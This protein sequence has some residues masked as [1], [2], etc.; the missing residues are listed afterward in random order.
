MFVLSLNFKTADVLLR[1]KFAFDNKKAL[2]LLNILKL[3]NIAE[4]VYLSTCNRCE[5]YG[6]GDVYFAI[7]VFSD[8]AEIS[9]ETVKKHILIFD[10]DGAVRHLFRV[11]SGIESMVFGEDEILGQI[12]KAFAFSQN[13]NATGYELNTIFKGAITSAKRIKT[14]T[15]ISKSSVSVATLAAS[16][17]HNFNGKS[18]KVLMIGGSGEIGS[19]VLK[20]LISYGEFDIYAT[21]RENHISNNN[22]TIIS[23]ADRY[24]YVNDADIIISAT[25]SPHFTI[26]ADRLQ[27]SIETAKERLFIDLAVPRDIDEDIKSIPDVS[28][29][30]IDDFKDIAK[31]NSEIKK[32]EL[33]TAEDMMC[34]DIDS[35]L[36]ELDFHSIVSQIQNINDEVRHFIYDFR[37]TANADEFESFINVFSKMEG[38]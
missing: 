6:V 5:I 22:L 35:L 30:Q 14:Q 32:D 34:E 13:N 12:K 16:K 8:F 24:K 36:K 9:E 27:K 11:C 20:D 19:K 4:C 18:K 33:K 21:A 31:R 1:E 3:N 10:G 37:D 25:K 26:V 2:S 28:L 15:L 29:M 23:Y 17:C 38:V 7:K